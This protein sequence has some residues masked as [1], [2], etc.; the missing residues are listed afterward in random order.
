MKL[1]TRNSPYCHLLT[2][3]DCVLLKDR[4]LTLAPRQG[5]EINSRASLWVSP[6]TCHHIQCWLTN[7]RLILL[8]I[9]CLEAPKTGS[10]PTNFTREPSLASW[11]PISSPR[12]TA[13][14]GPNT[15][16]QH[17]GL[18]IICSLTCTSKE[19]NGRDIGDA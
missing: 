1:F 11:S 16:L 6:R 19:V 17:A 3:L 10:G 18:E 5:P 7:Q 13:C 4:N 2:A 9:S 14:Q 8:R 12:A 15:A